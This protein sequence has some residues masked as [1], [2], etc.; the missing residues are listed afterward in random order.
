MIRINSLKNLYFFK[1][2]SE[3][4]GRSIG[5]NLLWTIFGSIFTQ[6]LTLVTFYFVARI[7]NVS[8]YGEF[9]LVRS[10]IFMFTIFVGYS[11]GIT[12]TKCVAEY[13]NT[14]NEKTGKIVGLTLKIAFFAGL[15][16]GLFVLIFAPYISIYSFNSNYLTQ[17]LR[18]SSIILFFSSLNGA[19]NGILAGFKCFKII[20]KINFFSSFIIVFTIP[21]FSIYFGLNGA[22]FGLCL[23]SVILLLFNYYYVNV[24]LKSNFI[25]L[26]FKDTRSLFGILHKFTLPALLSGIMGGPVTWICNSMLV[27]QPNG[28]ENIAV[29]DVAY[30]WRN[31]VLFF[32]VLLGQVILPYFTSSVSDSNTFRKMF[33]A[34]IILNFAFS[35]IVATIISLFAKIIMSMYGVK[36]EE[37]YILLIIL[38]FTT[39]LNSVNSVVGQAIA[40]KGK[41]WVGFYLNLV[42]GSTLILSTYLFLELGYSSIG[43]SISYLISYIIHTILS[44]LYYRNSLFSEKTLNKN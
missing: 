5:V 38:V 43:L 22:M 18:I 29:F 31:A 1:I 28:L 2:L 16:I 25:K 41:M 34:N 40:S 26:E 36:Y 24:T 12:A 37:G 21:V 14:D 27:R 23:N 15:I 33:R 42:W 44:Y 8:E 7:L 4:I 9:A 35:I 6:L 10:T 20:A 30:Q 32:P 11:L 39:V 13:N 17:E 19:L 3:G